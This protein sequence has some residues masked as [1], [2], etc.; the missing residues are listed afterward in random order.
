M[1]PK[2]KLLRRYRI[3]I[4]SIQD[5]L[6][7]MDTNKDVLELRKFCKENLGVDEIF[8]IVYELENQW[9]PEVITTDKW[10]AWKIMQTY[11]LKK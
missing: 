1:K 8:N 7:Y 5:K 10:L 9:Y 3:P 2:S 4:L 6:V 11:A